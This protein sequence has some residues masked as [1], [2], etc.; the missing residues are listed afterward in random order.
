[1]RIMAGRVIVLGFDALVLPLVKEFVG[2]GLLPNFEFLMKNGAIAEAMSVLPPYT[3]TNWATIATGALPGQHGA[4]NWDDSTVWDS[5]D[6]IPDS[7]FDARAL[8]A[9]T[10]W[11]AAA[12]QGISSLLLAY[13]GSYPTD[14][15]N[16]TVVAPLYRGLTGHAWAHGQEYEIEI[17][18]EDS[19]VILMNEAERAQ[20]VVPT[21]DGHHAMNGGHDQ[22]PLFY[23]IRKKDRLWISA[24]DTILCELMLGRWSNWCE[25]PK[26]GTDTACVRF[27]LVQELP[28]SI[29]VLRSE[30]Y[31]KSG[32]TYP[33]DYS[34]VV[35]RDLGPGFEH[36]AVFKRSDLQ[37]FE[38]VQ[39]E[40]KDQ[41]NWYFRI[42][43]HAA[44]YRPWRL[45]M[46]HWHWLDTAQHSYLADFDPDGD[47]P[48]DPI[49]VTIIS[50]SYQI[51]DD[52]LGKFL[53]IMTPDDHLLIVSDHGHVPNRRIASV[54]R[55]L[56]EA[57][58]AYFDPERLPAEVID[59]RRSRVY[60]LSPHQLAINLENRNDT[61]I[62]K[63]RDFFR[64]VREARDAL[65]DWKDPATGDRVVA[66]ALINDDQSL[67]GYFGPR[68][69]DV[70]FLFNQGYGWGTPNG[71]STIGPGDGSANHGSQLP[72][73]KTMRSSNLATI[74]AIGPRISVSYER[75]SSVKGYLSLLD[76]APLIAE[77]LGI[78]TPKDCRGAV[79]VDF[80][81]Y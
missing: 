57:G 72:T 46:H 44:L 27:R 43:Q 4:G 39:D 3:P 16:V 20:L 19:P 36:P 5:I 40:L 48:Q 73:A 66:Y 42:A 32:F 15:P 67:L 47:S 71:H 38:A 78:P 63:L 70:L 37:S 75:D 69:G 77:L 18:R 1:M 64:I 10:L 34:S 22:V 13:P 45:Y 81:K 35:Y 74:G 8:S 56:V 60:T 2:R 26:K 25:L 30:I 80:L 12:R 24:E 29:R 54:E 11:A 21:E 68:R 65:L 61:G 51:A 23:V 9:D 50:R 76:V 53:N 31:P 49:A 14:N 62:V 33:L 7:T 6:R 52:L 59:R 17:P 55:R 28:T 41:I 79:P 58:L